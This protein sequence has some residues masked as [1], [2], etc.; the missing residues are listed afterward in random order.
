MSNWQLLLWT[1]AWFF[2]GWQCRDAWKRGGDE[3]STGRGTLTRGL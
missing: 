2:L 3:Q 1:F